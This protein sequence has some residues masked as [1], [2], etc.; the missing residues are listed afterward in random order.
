MRSKNLKDFQAEMETAKREADRI[1]D[2]LNI[3]E[4]A[5]KQALNK[6]KKYRVETKHQAALT[7]HYPSGPVDCCVYHANMIA[8]LGRTMGAHVT[9]TAIPHDQKAECINCTN[10]DEQEIQDKEMRMDAMTDQEK[11]KLTLVGVPY[12]HLITKRDYE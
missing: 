8:H 11:L 4:Q 5:Y 10:M 7:V 1:R 2:K 3:A 12:H 9:M 6:F